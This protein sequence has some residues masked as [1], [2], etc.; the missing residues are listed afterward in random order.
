MSYNTGMYI[1]SGSLIGRPVLS[2][3]TGQLITITTG[4]IIDPGTLGIVALICGPTENI[5]KPILLIRDI[6]EL[7]V[8][9]MLV[10]NETSISETEDIIRI[11]PLTDSPYS[12][13]GARVTTETKSK[14]GKVEDYTVNTDNFLV[15]KIYVQPH[16][17][18][19]LFGSSLIIDR[20]Q[21]TDVTPKSIIVK[22]TTVAIPMGSKTTPPI[23]S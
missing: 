6:R 14:L 1:L 10:N 5:K 17:L 22:D 16:M 21:I 8:D 19:G 18:K 13:L 2:L 12:L 9:C 23:K 7:A 3:Q 4:T 20:S 11:K 15:Q